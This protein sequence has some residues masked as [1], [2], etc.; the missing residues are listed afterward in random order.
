MQVAL[1]H[2][3]RI[4]NNVEHY[5]A[6]GGQYYTCDPKVKAEVCL[7]LFNTQKECI[8]IV[9][10]EAFNADFFD[11]KILAILVACC[12]KIPHFLV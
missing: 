8:G 1:S 6:Q 11:E 3:G 12:I 7:P 10:A 4:I 5:L 2:Q 9:D